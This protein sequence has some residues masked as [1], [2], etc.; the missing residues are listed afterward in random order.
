MVNS[1]SSKPANNPCYK[2]VQNKHILEKVLLLKP[3]LSAAK[4]EKLN[5]I[6]HYIHS[7]HNVTLP[8]PKQLLEDVHQEQYLVDKFP[9]EKKIELNLDRLN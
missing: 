8:N 3:Q 6:S 1:V 9:I 4:P 5:N 7:P 2:S